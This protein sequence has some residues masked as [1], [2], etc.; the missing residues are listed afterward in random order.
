GGPWTRSPG[1]REVWGG[2]QAARIGRQFRVAAP[3]AL[4]LDKN[5]YRFGAPKFPDDTSSPKVVPTRPARPATPS[6]PPTA[7]P[8]TPAPSRTSPAPRPSCQPGKCPGP[9]PSP[10]ASLPP[11]EESTAVAQ[12]PG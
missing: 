10:S 1:G 7:A 5:Q 8:G 2:S 12:G 3:A 11:A 9:K 6:R 4:K